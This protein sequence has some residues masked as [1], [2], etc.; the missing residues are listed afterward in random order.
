MIIL[1]VV[2]NFIDLY[3]I[4]SCYNLPNVKSF[5]ETFAAWSDTLATDQYTKA[6][7]KPLYDKVKPIYAALLEKVKSGRWATF[8]D[9]YKNYNN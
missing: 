8:L 5:I 6:M 7:Q 4:V 2:S 9:N 3:E 1:V